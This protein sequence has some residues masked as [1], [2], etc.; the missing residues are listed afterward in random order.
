MRAPPSWPNHFPKAPP[1]NPCT[2]GNSFSTYEFGGH[3]NIQT[4]AKMQE[5]YRSKFPALL[6]PARILLPMSAQA[7]NKNTMNGKWMVLL[8]I[9]TKE[10]CCIKSKLPAQWLQAL[11]FPGSSEFRIVGIG[12]S[13]SNRGKWGRETTPCVSSLSWHKRKH[14]NRWK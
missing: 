8:R 10:I 6:T 1:P 9:N 7:H 4:I 5:K 2:M 13:K 12:N 11:V 14:I 3:T